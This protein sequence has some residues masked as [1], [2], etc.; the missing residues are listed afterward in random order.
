MLSLLLDCSL[1]TGSKAGDWRRL[2]SGLKFKAKYLCEGP[3]RHISLCL[4]LTSP[5]VLVIVRKVF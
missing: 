3:L 4:F 1:C 2:I 5:E